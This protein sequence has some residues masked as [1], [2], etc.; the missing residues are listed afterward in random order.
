LPTLKLKNLWAITDLYQ[1][2]EWHLPGIGRLWLQSAVIR[3]IYCNWWRPRGVTKRARS[4][5]K[6]SR[7][8][9]ACPAWQSSGLLTFIL[10]SLYLV[11][12]N[13]IISIVQDVVVIKVFVLFCYS[14]NWSVYSN[15]IH[16]SFFLVTYFGPQ[17]NNKRQ[18]T[19]Y[20]PN[21]VCSCLV[22]TAE[23]LTIM[24]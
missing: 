19:K 13:C 14:T 4:A 8:P 5:S 22:P 20:Y 18:C 10:H 16:Y 9:C 17:T 7:T 1:I 24:L 11:I 23:Y 3:N 2:I 21:L 12:R 15:T 6:R